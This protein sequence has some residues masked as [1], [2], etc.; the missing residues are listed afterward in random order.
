MR[1]NFLEFLYRSLLVLILLAMVSCTSTQLST[2]TA[3]QNTPPTKTAIPL[4]TNP[5]TVVPAST[6]TPFPTAVLQQPFVKIKDLG[7]SLGSQPFRFIGANAPYFGAYGQNGLSIEEGIKSAREAGLSVLR[8]YLTYGAQPWGA[9]S[10]ELFDEV[11]DLAAQN[12]IYI[13]ATF[14]DGCCYSSAEKS[15]DYFAHTVY[16]NINNELSQKKFESFIKDMILRKNSVNGRIY[17]DDPTIMAWDIINVPPVE[18]FTPIELNTW[19]SGMTAYIK[20]IDP[21]HLVT[22]GIDTSQGIYSTP[23]EHYSALN[24][25]DLD[26][27]SFHYNTNY[28]EDAPSHLDSIRYRVEMFRSMGK[29]VVMDVFGSGSQRIFPDNASQDIL[30]D[31]VKAYKD[32]MDTVFS[33][34]AAGALFWGWGVPGTKQVLLWW[35]DEDHDSTETLFVQMLLEYQFPPSAGPSNGNGVIATPQPPLAVPPV[36][37]VRAV[38]TLVGL[39]EQTVVS[40]DSPVAIVWGWRADSAENMQAYITNAIT[41]VTL[42]GDDISSHAPFMINKND[43]GDFRMLWYTRVGKLSPGSHLIMIDTSWKKMISDG[44]D[45]YGPGGKTETLHD[46]CEI[47]VK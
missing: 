4:D 21:N 45:T 44:T 28:F 12:G 35:S 29:P 34:G 9:K 6:V 14:A 30:V 46:E 17:R 32:Q 25:P 41:M 42:D 22:L 2:T 11:L 47:L 23:G 33:A 31:W 37:S 24:V 3:N 15:E 40:P 27:F 36:V 26:F 20:S 19:L 10:F 43:P 7:F 18:L 5:P 1:N 16:T 38:C 39:P 8:I 13:I